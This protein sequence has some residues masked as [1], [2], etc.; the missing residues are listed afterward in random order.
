[1]PFRTFPRP[2]VLVAFGLLSGSMIASCAGDVYPGGGVSLGQSST[3][4]F[5]AAE[6][7]TAPERVAPAARPAPA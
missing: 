3:F 1:M 6:Q 4:G 2:Q 5:I 7:L